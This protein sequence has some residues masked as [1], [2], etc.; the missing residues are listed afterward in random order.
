MSR[1]GDTEHTGRRRG[2]EKSMFPGNG[3]QDWWMKIAA[4]TERR[5]RLLLSQTGR[6]D[7]KE[8]EFSD[9]LVGRVPPGVSAFSV[10]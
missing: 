9:A 3:I 8:G 2:K 1:E 6:R 5:K 10:K 4:L 7:E